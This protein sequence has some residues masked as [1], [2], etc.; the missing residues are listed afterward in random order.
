MSNST[1]KT[2][3][4]PPQA[5]GHAGISAQT[6]RGWVVLTT[7]CRIGVQSVCERGRALVALW[8]A[9]VLVVVLY[10]LL[11]GVSALLEP[12]GR[13]QQANGWEASFSLCAVFCGL[14]PYAVYRIR[15]ESGNRSPLVVAMAQAVWCGLCG[16]VCGWFFSL[17][18]R[19]FGCGHDLAT[20]LKKMVVDQFCWSVLVIVPANAVF[21]AVLSGGWRMK[22][23]RV[24]FRVF[25]SRVYL[26]NLLMNWVVGIPSN[27]AVYA[28][29]M[30][31][32][33][34]VLGLLSSAW[35]V[36]CTGLGARSGRAIRA[37]SFPSGGGRR[38]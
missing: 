31:L 32:Q 35:A 8:T 14:I 10:Y 17:Q 11:P 7:A 15:R 29:P 26:P 25:L 37:S 12:V 30:D 21:Y 19:W 9:A 16:V 1:V 6:W 27:C 23:E 36:I 4:T 34:P 33:I 38:F 2:R 28:F 22:D 5:C 3:Q 24:P 20:V 13:W 18:G